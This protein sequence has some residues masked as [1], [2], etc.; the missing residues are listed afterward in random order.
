MVLIAFHVFNGASK[1]IK[2]FKEKYPDFENIIKSSGMGAH[3][4]QEL[5]Y[6]DDPGE[7]GYYLASN[8]REVERL[9]KLPSYEMKRELT[10]HM[11]EMVSKNH[12]TRA[13]TPIKTVGNGA[14]D[15]VKHF[16]H[17]T[18]AELKAERRAQLS[19]KSRR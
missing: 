11:R 19:G 15:S 12:V 9:Q 18:I 5:I 17:K 3:I 16:A 10:R 6:F 7:L 4:A 1:Y 2:A 13:P 14:G 8:P